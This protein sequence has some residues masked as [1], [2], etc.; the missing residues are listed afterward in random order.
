MYAYIVMHLLALNVGCLLI[1]ME[2]ILKLI[3]ECQM[4]DI[5]QHSSL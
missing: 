4:R 3:Q 1:D 5:C 2:K